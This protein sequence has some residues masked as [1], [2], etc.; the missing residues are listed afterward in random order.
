MYMPDGFLL[1]ADPT[2]TNIGGATMIGNVFKNC[3]AGI[4]IT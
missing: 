1:K 4:A 3:G 2:Q